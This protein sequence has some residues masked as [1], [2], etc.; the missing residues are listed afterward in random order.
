MAYKDKKDQAVNSKKHYEANKENIK[1]R[2]SARNKLQRDKNIAYVNEIKR[3]TPCVDCGCINP[4]LLEFDHVRGKKE[5]C[6]SNMV[7]GAYSIDTIQ[8]EIDKCEVRCAN[9]HR[10]ITHKRRINK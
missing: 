8:K 4:V 6:I 9:C 2:S 10:L 3:I 7:R 1:R 5:K